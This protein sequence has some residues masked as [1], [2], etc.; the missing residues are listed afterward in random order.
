MNAREN[1]IVQKYALSFVEKVSDHADIWD[2]YDQ[3][4]D[5]ISIIHDSKAESNLAV[6]DSIERRKG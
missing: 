3:I 2:M 6:S 1:A 4:S 5:L